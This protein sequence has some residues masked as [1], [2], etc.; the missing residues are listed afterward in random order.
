MANGFYVTI[1]QVTLGSEAGNNSKI[2]SWNIYPIPSMG[3]VYLPT[4]TININHS[5]IG[6]YT[7]HGWY[8]PTSNPTPSFK[9]TDGTHGFIET[10][11]SFHG[12]KFSQSETEISGVL[13]V[14]G[15]FL[16]VDRRLMKYYNLAQINRGIHSFHQLRFESIGFHTYFEW[17]AEIRGI[18]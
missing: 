9:K 3:L 8:N 1:Y 18:F 2:T 15:H 16:R 14:S 12:F 13:R 4:F 6:K 11:R 10:H 5:C 17:M 7:T